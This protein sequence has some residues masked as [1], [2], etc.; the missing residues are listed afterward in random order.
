MLAELNDMKATSNHILQRAGRRNPCKGPRQQTEAEARYGL[1]SG[2]GFPFSRRVKQVLAMDN[3]NHKLR[4]FCCR[5]EALKQTQQE[6]KSYKACS[7]SQSCAIISVETVRATL[8]ALPNEA[9]TILS[10]GA[11]EFIRQLCV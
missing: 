9:A 1:F 3:V 10:V 7:V 8:H 4:D 2:C 5:C 6:L 11:D